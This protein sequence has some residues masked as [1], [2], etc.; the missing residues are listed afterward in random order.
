[1]PQQKGVAP[2]MRIDA[3][4]SRLTYAQYARKPFAC[5]QNNGPLQAWESGPLFSIINAT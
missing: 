3:L 4:K 1:M 2:P 5:K